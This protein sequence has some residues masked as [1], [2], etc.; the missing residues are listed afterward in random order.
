MRRAVLA[1][2]AG[3]TSRVILT[4]AKPPKIAS[5]GTA[6]RWKSQTMFCRQWLNQSQ[7][8]YTNKTHVQLPL[9]YGLDSVLA[10]PSSLVN[11]ELLRFIFQSLL[12]NTFFFKDLHSSAACLPCHF[13][14][15]IL[16]INPLWT[17]LSVCSEACT[18]E[19]TCSADISSVTF[20]ATLFWRTVPNCA[21]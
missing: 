16:L 19:H 15:Q 1:L 7:V 11:H 8:N 5:T 18:Q 17:G 21:S 2:M 20:S 10:L 6:L 9:M 3:D 13:L 4:T 12:W 14:I